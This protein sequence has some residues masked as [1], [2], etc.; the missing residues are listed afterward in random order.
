MDVNM[1]NNSQNLDNELN[2]PLEIIDHA[3]RYTQRIKW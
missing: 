2:K 1:H 3:S